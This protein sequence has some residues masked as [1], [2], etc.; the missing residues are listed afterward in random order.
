MARRPEDIL[1]IHVVEFLRLAVKRPD[2][3]WFCPNGGNLSRAQAGTFKAMG[4]TPG[5]PDMHFMWASGAAR[6]FPC[7]GVIELKA[8]KNTETADQVAF[9]KD[10]AAL[11]HTYAVCRSIEEVE[12]TLRA[13]SFPLHATMLGSGVIQRAVR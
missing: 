9:G 3:F 7:Y 10:A 11:G 1:Q 4:L 13:W 5:V 12:R 6:Q 2:R 8:G